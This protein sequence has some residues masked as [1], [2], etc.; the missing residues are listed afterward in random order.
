MLY[1]K[2]NSIGKNNNKVKGIKAA[3]IGRRGM[4]KKTLERRDFIK[5]VLAGAPLIAWDWKSFPQGQS[6]EKKPNEFDAIIIG[7]GL[8]GLS[9]AAAFA[10][11]GFKPLVLEQHNIPGGYATSFK[12]P[13]GF[14]FDASLHSTTVGERDGVFNLI[15]GFPELT[16]VEF[17]PHPN[18]YRAIFPDHDIRAPQKDL[19]GY[20]NILKQEFPEDAGNI[21]ALFKDMLGFVDD[22]NRYQSAAGKVDMSTFP[23]DFPLLFKYINATWGKMLNTHI[24]NNQLQAVISSQWGYYGLPPSKLA[25]IYYVLPLIGYLRGGGYYPIGQS[26]KISDAFAR[27]IESNGGKIVYKTQ[28]E[29]ILIEDRTAV[30]VQTQQGQEYRSKVVVS[31]ASGFDTFHKMID[32]GDYLKDYLTR[33][34]TFTASLS[35]FQVW[36][37]LK[38]D[39]IGRLGIKDSE[40]FFHTDYDPESAYKGALNADVEDGELGLTLYD[41]LYKGYSPRGKNTLN[42]MVLQGYD[43]WK[44]FESDYFQGNK[45]AYRRE[46]E[47]IADILI[48]RAEEALLPGLS[49]AIEIKVAA[50]PLTNVRYTRNYRGALYGWDQTVANSMPRRVSHET[51]VKNLYLSGAWTQPGGGYG[52]VIPS[53]LQ[54]FGTIMADW[55]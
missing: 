14:V 11:Q 49:E 35:S 7:A 3:F 44:S 31:N 41:N 37:G 28:V 50:T 29:K 26:Q 40:I 25:C 38:Q 34:A 5:T 15:Q 47:R 36:L 45:S 6:K 2:I 55:K 54:C 30:G 12:R 22:L 19:D 27:Y 17:V 52:A 53:G 24:K 18:L 10:R 51:P 1:Y 20:I 23:K 13:G 46:K 33:M 42:I 32:G 39:L 4:F 43:L 21:D 48:K 9:C 16:E 8:G